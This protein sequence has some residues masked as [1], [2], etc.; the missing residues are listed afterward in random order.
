MTKAGWMPGLVLLLVASA[1][2]KTGETVAGSGSE[3]GWDGYRVV[4]LH[5]T[6]SGGEEG[7]TTHVY[8]ASGNRA[9]SVW[10]LLDGTRWSTNTYVYD[11]AGRMVEKHRVFSD[12]LTSGQTFHYDEKGRLIRETFQRSDGKEG[13][14]RYQFSEDGKGET[15]RCDRMNGWLSGTI[16]YQLDAEG[17][18]ISG[19]LERD[20]QEIGKITF[21][22]NNAGLLEKE[23]WQIGDWSQT[24][25]SEYERINC[26]APTTSNPYVPA[27]CDRRVKDE[28]YSFNDIIGGP[29]S[30]TYDEAGRLTGKVF[31]RSDGVQTVTVYYYDQANRL[32]TS[33]RKF[34]DGKTTEFHYVYNSNR[35]L[36]KRAW[37]G[38]AGS[39]GLEEYHYDENG[40][41]S[42]ARYE[43]MDGWLTGDLTFDHDRYGHLS[44]GT[45]KGDDGLIAD[46][47]FICDKHGLPERIYWTLSSGHTQEYRFRYEPVP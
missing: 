19:V 13:H 3:N 6:N 33:V 27:D 8:A 41:L 2:L 37:T 14:V 24:F 12:G 26:Q 29:S 43:R 20:S 35:Q 28:D 44:T 21:Q 39:P 31:A 45:Y 46:I 17:R 1:C 32:R 38:P 25:T 15:V 34:G 36:V 16:R 5:Y 7:V 22:Y 18:R 42:T 40:K 23:N 11:D 10:E 9:W 4:R 30:Y 47:E